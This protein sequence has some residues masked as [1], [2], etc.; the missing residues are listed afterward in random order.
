MAVG[1]SFESV[2]QAAQEGS[3]WAWELLFK[4]LAPK[5]RGYVAVR[6]AREPDDLVNETFIQ[7]A[8]NVGR[9]EGTEANFR[10]WVFTVAH[11]RLIDERRS[12]GRRREDATPPDDIPERDVAEDAEQLAIVRLGEERIATLLELL[13]PDQRDVL[14]LRI[15]GQLTLEETAQATG[16]KLG[17]VSQLQ[18][19]ALA[20]L[21]K[22]IEAEEGGISL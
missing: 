13:T 6:G 10:S 4:E 18:R 7:I 17:A 2:L 19:R 3:P 20:R 16:R 15:L 22:S 9:F 8:R 14:A 11:H 5:I 1:A 12:R 21:R